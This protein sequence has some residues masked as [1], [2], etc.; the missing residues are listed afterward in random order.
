MYRLMSSTLWS[1]FS[2]SMETPKDPAWI[3]PRFLSKSKISS[4][5]RDPAAV[6]LRPRVRARLNRIQLVVNFPKAEW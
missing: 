5:V 3:I 4:C 1:P 2:R 6:G